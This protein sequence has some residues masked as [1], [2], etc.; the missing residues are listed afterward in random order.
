MSVIGYAF[1]FIPNIIYGDHI[2]KLKDMWIILIQHS[3]ALWFSLVF[4]IGNDG[5]GQKYKS[6]IKRF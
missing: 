4:Q 6:D 1:S 5:Y 3:A 2:Y